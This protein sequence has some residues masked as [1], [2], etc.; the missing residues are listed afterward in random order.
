M[1]PARSIT[2]LLPLG[3][4]NMARLV[5]EAERIGVA[6]EDYARGLIEEGLAF[7]RQAESMNLAQIMRPVRQAAGTVT[8]SEIVNLVERARSDHHRRPAL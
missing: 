1:T 7:K 2:L 3:K 5:A 6:P 4:Q 8:E